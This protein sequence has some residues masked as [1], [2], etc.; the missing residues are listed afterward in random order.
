AARPPQTTA[1]ADP[2]AQTTLDVSE[3]DAS[4]LRKRVE[5]VA[6]SFGGRIEW[7]ADGSLVVVLHDA[8][9]ATDRAALAAR[10]ALEL[11]ALLPGAPFALTTGRGVVSGWHAVGEAI[12]RAAHMIRQAQREPSAVGARDVLLDDVT[13]GLLP[14][15]FDVAVVAARF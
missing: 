10:C 1:H 6:I 13:A 2:L 5:E 15:R 11:R 3:N 9:A 14:P 4:R 12:D 7:L 8:G